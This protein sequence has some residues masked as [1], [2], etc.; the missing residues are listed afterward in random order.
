M[1]RTRIMVSPGCGL[2]NPCW[3]RQS[4][5][6][7]TKPSDRPGGI[8]LVEL[9]EKTFNQTGKHACLVTIHGWGEPL[10]NKNL[11]EITRLALDRRIFMFVTKYNIVI[12]AL[13]N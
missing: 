1:L 8:A 3:N 11:A 2:R 5:L 9:H 13:T 7:T 6:K 4:N 12:F 10:M